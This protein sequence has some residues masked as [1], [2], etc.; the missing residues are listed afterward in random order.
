FTFSG[1]TNFTPGSGDITFNSTFTQTGGTFTPGTGALNFNN[2]FNQSGG[3]F[4]A[5]N[6]TL[7]FVSNVNI[8]GGTFNPNNGTID[9]TSNSARFVPSP[10]TLTLNG[11]RTSKINGNG[12][13]FQP[14][15]TLTANGP[16]TLTSGSMNSNSGAGIIDAKAAV[17]I[18]T[19]FGGGTATLSISGNATRTVTLSV[20]ASIP[21]LTVN[22]PNVTVNT[23]GAPGS[24][25][26]PQ[27]V[28][29]QDVL[30]F[31]ND[32]VN[33]VF[34]A[35]FTFAGGNFNPGSGDI[36]FNSTFTQTGATFTPGAGMMSF[37]SIFNLSGGTF[38]APNAT[39]T[40]VS[41][42]NITG[43]TFN[44]NNGTVDFTGNGASFVTFPPTLTLNGL[45]I[46][47][48]NGNAVLFQTTS[49]LTAT[50]P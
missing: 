2:V 13:F 18:E 16:V 23:S 46:S 43:G 15:T 7:S 14:N 42:V 5:P 29:L 4:N 24:I 44:P 45:R 10:A 34:N 47:K 8:T 20:G 30:S 1:N 35:P 3:T 27:P 37:N 6:T 50:G 11:L 17:T 41:N 26:F 21:A 40:F 12:F 33:F 25:S 19:T 38:N 28:T 31:G 32:A 36:A 39:L 9:F 49:T 22:A 48:V